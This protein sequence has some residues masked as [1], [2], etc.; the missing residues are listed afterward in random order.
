MIIVMIIAIITVSMMNHYYYYYYYR[1]YPSYYCGPARGAVP[2]SPGRLQSPPR[3]SA[4]G[5]EL[6]SSVAGLGLEALGFSL[7]FKFVA[8]YKGSANEPQLSKP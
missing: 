7:E 3:R 2:G 6:Q 8:F 5:G 4:P 1:Y